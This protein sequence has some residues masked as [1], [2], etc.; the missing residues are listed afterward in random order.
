MTTKQLMAYVVSLA[1]MAAAVFLFG[2]GI[3][4]VAEWREGVLDGIFLMMAGVLA[5]ILFAYRAKDA[6]ETWPVSIAARRT[7]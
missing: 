1:L 6:R 4:L 7:R 5:A 2:D 3:R